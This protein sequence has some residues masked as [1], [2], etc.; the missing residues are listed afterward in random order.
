MKQ[1]PVQ[2]ARDD[3]HLGVG[4]RFNPGRVQQVIKKTVE[5]EDAGF[6]RLNGVQRGF[7][8]VWG[9]GLHS[10]PPGQYNVSPGSLLALTQDNVRGQAICVGNSLK[11]RLLAAWAELF[12][13]IQLRQ[14]IRGCCHGVTILL[15]TC[16]GAK[17]YF[18]VY[19][20]TA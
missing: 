15:K 13:K 5:C 1:R 11:Q 4:F 17:S 19:Q 8:A 6:S 16:L 7:V 2:R 20:R 10:Q 3:H 12:E 9:E 14:R 18:I